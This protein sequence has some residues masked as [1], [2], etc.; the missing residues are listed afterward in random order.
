MARQVDAFGFPRPQA[1]CRG[2]V[3]V[4]TL[5]SQPLFACDADG[6]QSPA[7]V[8]VRTTDELY[9]RW[10][11]GE[12]EYYR[13]GPRRI[14]RC[15]L[16]YTTKWNLRVVQLRTAT[17]LVFSPLAPGSGMRHLS[18]PRTVI[19]GAVSTSRFGPCP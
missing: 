4:E 6:R 8:G 3:I 18:G 19:P 5:G 15:N 9:L 17:R 7:Y 16:A 10:A 2:R 14:E 13:Y 12:E 11:S 1:R